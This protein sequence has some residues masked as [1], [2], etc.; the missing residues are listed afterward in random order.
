[1][2]MSF[3]FLQGLRKLLEEFVG[4]CEILLKPLS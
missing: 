3:E 4:N 2:N 1:M